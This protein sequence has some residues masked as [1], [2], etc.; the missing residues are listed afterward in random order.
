M[1]LGLSDGLTWDNLCVYSA[2]CVNSGDRSHDHLELQ[3]LLQSQG[4]WQQ[5]G[6]QTCL[7]QLSGIEHSMPSRVSQSA[8]GFWYIA[9]VVVVQLLS[10]IRHFYDP[11]AYSL[12]GSS[13]HGVSLLP[14]PSPRGLLNPGMEPV[15][16]ALEADSLLLSHQGSLCILCPSLITSLAPLGLELA[17][18]L[19]IIYRVVLLCV[20]LVSLCGSGQVG[21]RVFGIQA[22]RLPLQRRCKLDEKYD[23]SRKWSGWFSHEGSRTGDVVNLMRSMTNLESG[24]ADSHMKVQGLNVMTLSLLQVVAFPPVPSGIGDASLSNHQGQ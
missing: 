7:V 16:P 24:L 13:I 23:K 21:D 14:L 19:I 5:R 22:Q 17:P 3:L 12:P 15:S 4:S 10:C 1:V 9:N 2:Q 8:T 6:L 20:A 11:M 18:L